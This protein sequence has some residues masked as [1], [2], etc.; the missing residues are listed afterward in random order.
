MVDDEISA[1]VAAVSTSRAGSM[2]AA[3]GCWGV[4][5]NSVR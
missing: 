3:V 1:L 2:A 4:L 5:S